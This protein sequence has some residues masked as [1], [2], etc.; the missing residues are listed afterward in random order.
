MKKLKL[1]KKI[2]LVVLFFAITPV[3]GGI[4][5]AE[6]L[7]D[8]TNNISIHNFGTESQENINSD[9]CS[10]ISKFLIFDVGSEESVQKNKNNQIYYVNDFVFVN[11]IIK[12]CLLNI[13]NVNSPFSP[14]EKEMLATIFK[15]E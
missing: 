8:H 3:F 4:C 6:I 9:D 7:L 10:R 12:N 5:Y 14:Y 13:I 11:S 15:K 2:K 1:F